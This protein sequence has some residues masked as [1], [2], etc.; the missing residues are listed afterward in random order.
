MVIKTEICAFSDYRI[1]PGNGMLF[2]RRDGRPV[3]LGSSKAKSMME[4]R[5]K[6]SKLVWTQAWRK[7]HKKGLSETVLKKRTR[8]VNKIQRAVVGASIDE[9]AKRST[10]NKAFR[11]AQ[12]KA[13]KKEIKDRKAA[14]KK[15]TKKSFNK[16]AQ[17]TKAAHKAHKM[18]IKSTQ[19]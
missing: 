16:S 3:T 9:I 14:A 11:D 13:A 10:Q 5:K 6:P 7:G 4:Q 8:K 15:D 2:V 1:Y 18:A 19:R 17:F 12:Q